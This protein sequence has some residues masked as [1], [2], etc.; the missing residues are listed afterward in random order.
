[1]YLL[2]SPSLVLDPKAWPQMVQNS[3][4]WSRLGQ[5]EWFGY[6]G[7]TQHSALPLRWVLYDAL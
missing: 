7:T 2:S 3:P 1:M 4:H 6:G 5:L